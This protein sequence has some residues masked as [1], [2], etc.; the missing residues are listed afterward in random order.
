MML[1]EAEA[2]T[3]WCPFARI[4]LQHDGTNVSWNRICTDDD[5]LSLTEHVR[6]I[7]SECMAWRWEGGNP[8]APNHYKHGYCGLAG[9]E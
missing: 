8:P 2:K 6:C 1:T 7:A 3:K 5:K 4:T 9:T